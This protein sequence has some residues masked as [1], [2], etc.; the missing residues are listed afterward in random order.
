MRAE[1][2]AGQDLQQKGVDVYEELNQGSEFGTR[3]CS[4]GETDKALVGQEVRRR[5]QPQG[6]PSSP[7][8]RW[9]SGG[10]VSDQS[11]SSGGRDKWAAWRSTEEVKLTGLMLQSGRGHLRR[12]VD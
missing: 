11:G 6:C 7:G 1:G 3:C 9:G 5:V 4:R 8:E 10:G 12:L 2:R